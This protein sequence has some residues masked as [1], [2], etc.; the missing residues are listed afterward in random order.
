MSGKCSYL[1]KNEEFD[2]VL[3]MLEL[4]QPF[5]EHCNKWSGLLNEDANHYQRVFIFLLETHIKE[6]ISVMFYQ[7][8][9]LCHFYQA[10]K[11]ALGNNMDT[12]CQE[13]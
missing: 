11:V 5:E 10:S 6:K 8:E 9:A 1:V 4:Q 3:G 13:M 2:L 12:V 7:D